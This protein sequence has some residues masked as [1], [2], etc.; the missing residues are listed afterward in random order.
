MRP[1]EYLKAVAKGAPPP[2][3]FFSGPEVR[4]KDQA[5][6]ALVALVPEGVRDF[7]VSV[8]HGFD[9]DPGEVVGAARTAPFMA[10]R[11]V[12]VLREA[13]RMRL[14]EGVGDLFAGYL[15][16]PS[17]DT[18]LVVATESEDR[19][20]DLRR[21]FKGAWVEVVFAALQGR[22]L[23]ERVR[24]EGEGLGLRVSPEAAAALVEAAGQDLGRIVGELGKLRSALG[25]GGAVGEEE[26]AVH[27]AGY[28]HR[29]TRDL[30]AAIGSRDLGRSLGIL[31]GLAMKPEDWMMFV[32]MLGRQLRLLWFFADGGREA[33][34]PFRVW[35]ALAAEL[36]R[37]AARFSRAEIDRGLALL[38]ETDTLMKGGSGLPQ[39][40]LFE[41]FLLRFLS[42]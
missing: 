2:A 26:V 31:A 11:R 34:P 13:D 25:E 22:E 27:V 28:S 33:P 42:P 14:S 30:L 1:A 6:A 24:A 32:G 20:K 37:D 4:L 35:P 39:R 7:N 16:D 5:I 36:R 38:H 19:A 12:V 18:A 8:Y 21:R 17:P 23:E 9:A 3:A 41:R 15:E 10:P 40:L 29:G